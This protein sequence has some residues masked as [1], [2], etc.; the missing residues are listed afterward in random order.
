MT[1]ERRTAEG[2]NKKGK[3]IFRTRL[4]TFAGMCGISFFMFLFMENEVTAAPEKQKTV[5]YISEKPQKT[6][7]EILYLTFDDGPSKENT[8]AVLDVLKARN[9]KATFFVIGEYV[10]KYP[11]TAKRIAEEGHTIGIHCD[12][13]DYD[14]LYES[15]DS[16]VADFQKAYDTVYE[17]TGVEAK[18]FRFPGGSVNAY[19]KKVCDDIIEEMTRRGFVYFDWNASLQDAAGKE[20]KPAQLVQNAKETALNRKTVVLLAH[21]RVKNTAL[22]LNDLLDAFSEYQFR[23]LKPYTK[24]VQFRKPK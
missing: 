6:E 1:N 9:V 3:G 20:V 14:V 7:S 4:C 16:Y 19:N 11:E 15:V 5:L 18:L 17:V 10:R 12:V 13:H 8:D 23:T 21:D 22:C 2:K 24:P